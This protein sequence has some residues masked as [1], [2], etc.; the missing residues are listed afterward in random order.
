MSCDN[1]NV[2]HEALLYLCIWDTN[3]QTIIE[4][5]HCITVKKKTAVQWSSL[6]TYFCGKRAYWY[7]CIMQ[8]YIL[9]DSAQRWKSV[10]IKTAQNHKYLWYLSVGHWSWYV[11]YNWFSNLLVHVH[12]MP[13]WIT[14]TI[15]KYEYWEHYLFEIM[16]ILSR[17]MQTHLCFT[18]VSLIMS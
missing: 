8:V 7:K 13:R 11:T 1:I 9:R 2:I 16:L 10:L 6:S 5:W 18:Q 4:C 14:V 12:P 17:E 15:L 3:C